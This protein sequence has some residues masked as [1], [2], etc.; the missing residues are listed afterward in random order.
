MHWGRKVLEIRPPVPLSK[1][2]A[3]ERLLRAS[4]CERAI[5]VGDDRTD[6]DAFEVLRAMDEEGALQDALCVAVASDE[7]PAELIEL[8]DVT[9]EG[10]GGVRG[11]LEA[12]L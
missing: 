6:A 1:G 8:A 5:Y 2:V 12:L 10:P 9:V 3:I 7:V 11:L 4:D